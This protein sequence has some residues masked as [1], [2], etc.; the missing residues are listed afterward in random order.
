MPDIT[1]EHN[2][3]PAK[4]EVMDVY[5]W[6]IW[7]KEVSSFPWVYDRAETCYFLEGEAL[8]TPVEGAPVRLQRGDLVRFAAGLRCTWEILAPVSKHYKF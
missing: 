5:E 3:T 7:N 2:P 8:V 1:I 6:P 4:L